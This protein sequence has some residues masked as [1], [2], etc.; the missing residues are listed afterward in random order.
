MGQMPNVLVLGVV[1]LAVNLQR[2]VVCF[3]VINFLVAAVQLP[4]TPRSQNL[5]LRCESLDSQ[6]ETNLIVALAGAAMHDGVRAFLLSDLNKTASDDRT[7]EGGTQQVAL[8][9]C[10]GLHGRDNVIINEF[11][12][13]IHDVQL[14]SAGLECLLFQ[15]VQLGSLSYVAGNSDYFTAVVF[16]QPRNQN[17]S[18][19]SAGICQNCLF[20]LHIFRCHRI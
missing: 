2:N 18:I 7:S 14:G 17:G 3:C 4:E 1:G 16:L 11:L 9:V 8:V 19:Q 15:T 5:H 6:L 10:A 13:Q 20:N 12:G